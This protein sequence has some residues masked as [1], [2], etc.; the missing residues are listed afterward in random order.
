MYPNERSEDPTNE[1]LTSG[2]VR[3]E[4]VV[5]SLTELEAEI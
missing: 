1:R 2:S 3:M 5:R 4:D